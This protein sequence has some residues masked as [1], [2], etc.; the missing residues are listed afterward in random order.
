MGSTS[1]VVVLNTTLNFTRSS[2]HTLRVQLY[3]A[4]PGGERLNGGVATLTLT[5][6][7]ANDHAPVCTAQT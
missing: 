5:V 3:N 7:D 1:G 6:V 2:N 4:P